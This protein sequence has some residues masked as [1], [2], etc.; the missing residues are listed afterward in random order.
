MLRR[1]YDRILSL[2]SSPRALW[3][4][5]LIAFAESSFFPIPPDALL[6]PMCVARPERAWRFGL[7]CTLASV[8][9]GALG[10]WIGFALLDAVARPILELYHYEHAITR[11]QET[12]AQYGLWVIL[13]KGLTPIPYKIVTIGS[14]AAHF[15]FG[16]FMLA[17]LATRGLRFF[18]EAALLRRFG[19]P[20]SHFV[21]K[22]L[23]LVTTLFALAVVGGFVLLK[24]L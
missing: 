15:N 21:E 24:L 6:I 22:R 8:A 11:F 20:V 19:A 13:L 16:I 1:L 18:L 23:T 5:G 17:S 4:L 3:W 2:A 7:I 9:G 12:Y 10:Y 14:G